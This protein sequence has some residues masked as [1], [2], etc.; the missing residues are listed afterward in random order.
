MQHVKGPRFVTFLYN[1]NP[2]YLIS[3]ALVL[4]GVHSSLQSGESVVDPWLMAGL[5]AGYTILLA[6]T[7]YLIVKIGQVWDDARSIF[8]VL[9]LLFMALSTNFDSLCLSSPW[10]AVMMLGLGFGFAVLI[11]ESLCWSLEIKFPR[12]FKVSYYLLVAIGFFYPLL[13]SARQFC[14]PHVDARMLL[15]CFPVVCS[16]GFLSLIPAVRR[17][18]KY[19]CK[20]GTPWNWPLYPY[21]VF[22]LLIVGLSGRTALLTMAFDPTGGAGSI[23]GSYFLVP[24]VIAVLVVL[25]EIAVVERIVDLQ[26]LLMFVAPGVM[27][28]ALNWSSDAGQATFVSDLTRT[29]GSPVWISLLLLV[30]FYAYAMTRKVVCEKYLTMAL[31]CTAIMATNGEWVNGIQEVAIWPLLL[32][33]AMQLSTR[34]RRQQSW[35]WLDAGSLLSFGLGRVGGLA[36]GPELEAYVNFHGILLSAFSVG[37]IFEDRLAKQIRILLAIGIP[38]IVALV[39]VGTLINQGS[40]AF[41][42]VY[43]CAAVLLVGCVCL[44]SGN[45]LFSYS[46][47]ITFAIVLVAALVRG[48]ADL[49]GEHQKLILFIACGLVFFA[50]GVFVSCLKAGLANRLRGEVERLYADVRIAFQSNDLE[51]RS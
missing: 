44:L 50:I 34:E 23:F 30:C 14:F 31:A 33:A 9:L 49:G 25:L 2:F 43:G 10:M 42:V 21:S 51:S 46:T 41:A 13:M 11:T 17:N 8:M 12:L 38:L 7:S 36:V 32:L 19:V 18:A 40:E 22:A 1:H 15:F 48:R 35:R 26:R 37:F 6:I 27:L 28:L 29:V 3:A 5:F 24:I 20:N 16:I 4:Y 45:R 47:G 39:W